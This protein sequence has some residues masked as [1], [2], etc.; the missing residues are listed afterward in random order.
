MSDEPWTWDDR[1]HPQVIHVLEEASADLEWRDRLEC[2]AADAIVGKV[3]CACAAAAVARQVIAESEAACGSSATGGFLD[4]LSRWIDDPTEDRFERIYA[5]LSDEREP[6]PDT[7]PHGAVWWALRTATSSV[8]N[9]EA[10]WAL[11]G[12]CRAAMAAGFRDETLREIVKDELISRLR[13][14]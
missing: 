8:G 10:G 3:L 13:Q 7:D 6:W 9:Y 1:S 4:L 12:V 2:A 11:N 14:S 5:L